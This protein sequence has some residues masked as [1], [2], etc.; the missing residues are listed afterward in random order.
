M[1]LFA[2]PQICSMGEVW[3]IG[4]PAF[5]KRDVF[6]GEPLARLQCS[7]TPCAILL[8][9]CRFAVLNEIDNT[10]AL[11]HF[12]VALRVQ[13]F[14]H[15]INGVFVEPTI[16]PQTIIEKGHFPF[17]AKILSPF[18]THHMIGQ[19]GDVANLD[20]SVNNVCDQSSS[21]WF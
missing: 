10:V 20:S 5:Q 14:R 4:W 6:G 7:G 1:Y 3:G 13:S 19:S 2:I 18:F 11:Q 9:N 16:P 21:T 8:E 12:D 17:D 15:L